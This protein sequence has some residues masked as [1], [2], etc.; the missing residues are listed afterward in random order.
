MDSEI[1][2]NFQKYLINEEGDLVDVLYP[3]TKP[4]DERIVGWIEE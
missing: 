1:K 3:K 2:W 4:M